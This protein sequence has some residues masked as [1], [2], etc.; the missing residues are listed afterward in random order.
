LGGSRHLIL[1]F[2]DGLLVDLLVDLVVD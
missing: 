2:A 1:E